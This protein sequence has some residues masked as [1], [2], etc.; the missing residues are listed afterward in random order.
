[1]DSITPKMLR[2]AIVAHPRSS[3]QDALLLACVML[4]A[5][6][7]ALQ[8]DLFFFIDKLSA[9]ERKISLA[10]AMFLTMLLAAC[11]FIFIV[12]RLSDQRHDGAL[13][14]AAEAELGE[15]TALIMQD[16]LTGLLNRRAMLQALAAAVAKPPAKTKDALFMIDLDH[17]KGV[18]DAHGHIVGD[19]VL[20][21]LADRFKAAAR[22]HDIVARI[23][24]DEFAVLSHNVD[25]ETAR[26]IGMRFLNSLADPIRAGGHNHQIGMSVGVAVIP[27]D[28]T[29]AEEVLQ[30]ADTAMY[31]AKAM[32]SSPMFF[33]PVMKQ[34]RRIA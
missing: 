3:S 8:Y 28:G 31:R 20:E 2:R 22:P 34:K 16:P 18:N 19:Q 30:H 5:L 23:G 10:E 27:D 29:T 25:R 6:L 26:K 11:M 32:R 12:R 21:V 9:P 17:F 4:V 1:V 14:V 33:E 13:R 7:L 24:G 15:L